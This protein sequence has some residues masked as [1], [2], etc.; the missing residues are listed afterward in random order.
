M[1]AN[2]NF[3]PALFFS[4]LKYFLFAGIPFFLLYRLFKSRT[5][6]AKL[7]NA[8]VGNKDLKREILHSLQSHFIFLVVALLFF[9]TPLQ[10]YTRMYTDV[11]AYPLWWIPLSL[12][13]SLVIHD[14]YFYWMHR[15]VHKG[16]LYKYIHLLHHKSINPTPFASG[17]FHVF[18]AF[19]EVLILPILLFLLPMHIYTVLI[20]STIVLAINVYGHLGYEVMPKCFRHS[21]LF[22][23]LGSSVYHNLHHAQFKGNYGLYFRVWDRLMKTENPSYVQEYDRI[24]QKRFPEETPSAKEQALALS[25]E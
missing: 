4:A 12:L 16:K 22:E 11:Q 18:E 23:I 5:Q 10:A 25:T 24:Q 2:I 6:K 21:F 13:M 9:N 7:Q 19:T 14:T 8:T 17:S 1:E 3:L 15:L 20:F